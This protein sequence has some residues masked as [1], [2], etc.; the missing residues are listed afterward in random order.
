MRRTAYVGAAALAVHTLPMVTC[1]AA[2]RRRFLPGLAGVGDPGR[3]ALTFDD[4]PDPASTPAFLDALDDLGWK[5]TFFMLGPMVR[6]APA[7][8]AEVASAG[9]EIAVHGERHSSH[10]WRSPR[11]LDTD[12]ARASDTL[13]EATGQP[14]TWF[15][16]PYGELTA[17]S[18]IAARRQRLRPVL[19]TAWGR[20]WRTRATPDS[21]ATD[22]ARGLHPGATVLLH[23]SDCMSSPGSWRATLASLPAL[24]DLFAEHGLHPGRLADHGL[25]AGLS[26]WLS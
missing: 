23:D 20:D 22:I 3:I 14:L 5:A 25:S 18:L 12:L 26:C 11:D 19:W 4:G 7:L 13:T 1:V 17:G 24:A 6:R 9:H 21:V 2:V 16:P 10:L 15:R 8:A